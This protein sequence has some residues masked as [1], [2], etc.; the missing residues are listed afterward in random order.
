MPPEQIKAIFAIGF[1]TE[2]RD[3]ETTFD[4]DDMPVGFNMTVRWVRFY[5]ELAE[6]APMDT[7]NHRALVR[8]RTF[9]QGLTSPD[10]LSGAPVFF[11]YMDEGLNARVGFAGM[12]TQSNGIRFALY[13]AE[14]IRPVLDR[15]IDDDGRPASS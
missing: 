10:G 6:P 9:Q 3:S 12:I 4:D 13:E 2:A 14:T 15:Y 11:V 8:H 1:P 5:L 7:E